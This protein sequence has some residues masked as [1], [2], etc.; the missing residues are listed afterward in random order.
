M[1]RYY[2]DVHE[3]SGSTR[4]GHGVECDSRAEVQR[5]AIRTLCELIHHAAPQAP[6]SVCTTVR[7]STGNFV[8]EVVLMVSVDWVSGTAERSAEG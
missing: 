3:P 8:L 7:D 4:D 6:E 5:Q 2:F 1:Q